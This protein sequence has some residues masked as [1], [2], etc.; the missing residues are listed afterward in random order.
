MIFENIDDFLKDNSQDNVVFC[1]ANNS[2]FEMTLNLYKSALRHNINLVVFA[3]DQ[4]IV[5]NFSKESG[6]ETNYNIVKYFDQNSSIK[7][8]QFYEYGKESFK[9][10]LWQRFLIGNRILKTG[11]TYIYLDTD[12]VIMKNFIQDTLDSLKT[13]NID[14]VIQFNGRDC[15]TGYFA[16]RPT[17]NTLN[18]NLQFLERLNYQKYTTNQPFFNGILVKNR[19]LNVMLLDRNKYPNGKYYYDN[20][21]QIENVCYLIHFNCIVGYE[22]KINKMK[23]YCKWL[24]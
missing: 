16:M 24:I 9:N 19:L 12:I 20:C 1:V 22:N 11:K 4:N 17:R 15:C 3:L 18:F 7:S 2:I 6:A 13:N 8:D 23:N 14:C 10:V 21:K 5:D